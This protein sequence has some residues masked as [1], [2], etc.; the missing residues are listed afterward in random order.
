MRPLHALRCLPLL[1]L[2]SAPS[3]HADSVKVNYPIGTTHGFLI[4]RTPEEK[5]LA[6][7]DLTQLVK[8][9]RIHIR[10]VFHFTDGSV[11]DDQAEYTQN[12]VFRLLKEHHIQKGPSYPKPLDLT[13]DVPSGTVTTVDKDGKPETKHMDLPPDLAN[14]LLLTLVLNLDPA[15]PKTDFPLL[16]GTT[17]L[18]LVH[19]GVTPTGKVPFRAGNSKKA[20]E[21]TG[22]F[23]IGGIAGVIAPVVGKQPKDIHFLIQEGEP[24]TFVREEGQL[25]EG[26]PVWRIEQVGPTAR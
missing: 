11:D 10:L 17:S 14:A 13:V 12:G 2:L 7:G 8:G 6:T 3:I 24:P 23:E 19:L 9:D 5:T 1:A 4:L 15:T 16:V 22:H 26:G 18:R 21:F 20:Q 25:Y